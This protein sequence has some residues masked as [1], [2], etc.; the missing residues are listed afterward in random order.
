[1]INLI[2][3]AVVVAVF[4]APMPVACVVLVYKNLTSDVV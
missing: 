2:I 4:V 1:M 3:N